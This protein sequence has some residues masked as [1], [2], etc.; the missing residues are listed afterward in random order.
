MDTTSLVTLPRLE[1]IPIQSLPVQHSTKAVQRWADQ[2]K[3]ANA[4]W[5][6]IGKLSI[7][8]LSSAHCAFLI[9]L[10]LAALPWLAIF[11]AIMM[12]L[13]FCIL[14][15]CC[16]EVSKRRRTEKA[17]AP[18]PELAER[19][20]A[21]NDLCTLA[22]DLN[23][24]ASNWNVRT[25]CSGFS[26]NTNPAVLAYARKK[27]EEIAVRQQGVLRLAETLASLPKTP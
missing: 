19:A 25:Q 13:G 5:R 16:R 12:L 17:L 3:A 20:K 24:V 9:S 26:R 11:W 27:R 6:S 23:M 10:S 22:S 4:T 7:I 14:P 8:G 15:S 21:E 2:E 18:S 1:L